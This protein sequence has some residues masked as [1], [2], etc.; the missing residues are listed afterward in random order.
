V[1]N[2]R[3]PWQSRIMARPK[4]V[5]PEMFCANGSASIRSGRNEALIIVA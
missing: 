4:L 2:A 1:S 3:A 5:V